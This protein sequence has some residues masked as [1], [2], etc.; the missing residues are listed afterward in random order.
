[1]VKVKNL[2]PLL[3][4]L[5]MWKVPKTKVRSLIKLPKGAQNA[6]YVQK[7]CITRCTQEEFGP[8]RIGVGRR[9]SSKT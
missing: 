4:L 7:E 9:S 1:L 3:R 2:Q 6:P 8:N 5:M